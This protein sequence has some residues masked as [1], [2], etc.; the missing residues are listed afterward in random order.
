[1]KI[2]LIQSLII[3]AGLVSLTTVSGQG[4]ST[5]VFGE[6]QFLEQNGVRTVFTFGQP[7]I[8]LVK[9]DSTGIITLGIPYPFGPVTS[10][11]VVTAE[12][13]DGITAYPNPASYSMHLKRRNW[14]KAMQVYLLAIDGRMLSQG[15]WRKGQE[16]YELEV[17]SLP[18]G[19]YLLRLVTEK[20]HR[21][22]VL[23]LIK[24]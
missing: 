15:E 1:M 13:P 3:L 14:E 7:P 24:Q 12:N 23:Q 4:V 10:V 17:A 2:A 20:V 11:R 22:T 9:Y 21:S 16:Y 6:I 19:I 8:Q 18:Q 5:P